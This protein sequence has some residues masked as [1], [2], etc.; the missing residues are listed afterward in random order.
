MTSTVEGTSDEVTSHKDD[1]EDSGTGT[2]K[3]AEEE[4][5]VG[6]EKRESWGNPIEFVLTALGLAVGL[7]N[8]WKFP[9]LVH[10]HGGSVFLIPYITCGILFGLPMIYLEFILGQFQ[11][12]S[13]PIVFRRIAPVYQGNFV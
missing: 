12:V 1:V 8:V 3:E 5:I 9:Y 2:K 13:P 4:E 7:G 6:D 11:R 10:K